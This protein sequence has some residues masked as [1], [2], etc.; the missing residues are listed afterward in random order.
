MLLREIKKKSNEKKLV[1]IICP[2]FNEEANVG[3]FYAEVTKALEPVAQQV[4]FEFV[5]VDDGSQDQTL[6]LLQKLCD[7]DARISIVKLSRNYGFQPAIM[8]GYKHC[9]GDAAIQIDS[10]LEDPPEIMC[11]FILKWLSGHQIVYGIREKRQESWLK[12]SLR[13]IFYRIMKRI[14][15]QDL[16][17]DAGDFML[18]DR[19]I[20]N[21]LKDSRSSNLYL[22]GTIY[23]MGFSRV[24]I[25]LTRNKRK[26][27]TSK[28]PLFKMI[29][30]AWDGV[31]SQ[32]VLPLRLATMV[33]FITI[34]VS[35]SLGLFYLGE[36]FIGASAIPPGWMT[37]T[38]ITLFCLG[39]NAMFFGIIGEYIARIYK[40]TRNDP[41]STV[42]YLH[43]SCYY[44]LKS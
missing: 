21:V 41:I 19:K 29:S 38:L 39:M 4:D 44:A 15:D 27:G 24:G 3:Y 30:L 9:N 18:I 28:F 32:S 14:S 22:R 23:S 26:F 43:R 11:D 36:Y 25:A 8:T 35:L 31:I 6:N 33:G 34:M 5:F 10:D 2:M 37:L 40:Q 7:Q 42:E 1:S 20:I 13:K 12:E 16:P 17:V